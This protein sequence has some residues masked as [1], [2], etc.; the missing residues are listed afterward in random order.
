MSREAKVGIFVLIGI[1]V[2]TFFTLR[3]SRWGGFGARGYTITVDFDSAAG[4][5]PKADVRMAG[6]P[7]GRVEE[8][9]LVGHRARLVLRIDEGIVIP[10]DAAATVRSMGLLGEKYVE[11]VP[12]A[13]AGQGNPR[14][15]E[16]EQGIPPG[17]QITRTIPPADIEEVMRKFSLIADDV[18]RVTETLA[19]ALG[20][21]ERKQALAETIDNIR[22][23]SAS[24]KTVMAA[25]EE[26]LDRIIVNVDA[27]SASL[28]DIAE[29]NRE[30][31]RAIVANLRDLSRTLA[32][33]APELARKLEAMGESVSGLIDDNREEIREA[34]ASIR[35]ASVKLDNTLESASAVMGRIERGE[36]TIGKLVTDDTTIETLNETLE[37]INRFVR[38]TE[39]LQTFLDYRLEFQTEPSEFKHYVN[40]RIQPSVD[41]YYLLGVVDDPLGRFERTDTTTTITPPGD[42]VRIEEEKFSDDLKF[43]VLVAKRFSRFTVRGGIMESKGGLGLD[44][45]TLR[46][47]FTVSLDAFDF[48]RRDLNPRLKLYGNYDIVRNFYVTGGVDDLLNDEGNLRTFFL[49]FGIRFLDEDIK[50]VLGAVPLRP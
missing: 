49:G 28:R 45:G 14:G 33:E 21:E 2:L 34:I 15:A 30:D 22:D 18:K 1:L 25:N 48:G 29:A 3:I 43:N 46:D 19:E 7:I 35:S 38:R 47:R 23:V 31:I 4:L 17:G 10:V 9:G 50:T 27:L 40:L 20:T 42:T 26:R 32:E 8:I 36:G 12:G 6:V 24:L 13:E 41:K 39:R 5:Q 44:Y 11:I 37:G 16:A